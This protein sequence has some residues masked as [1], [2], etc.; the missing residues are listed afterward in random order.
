M[1]IGITG[2]TGCGKSYIAAIFQRL[3]IE[4]G[5]RSVIF[6]ADQAARELRDKSPEV[7]LRIKELLGEDVYDENGVSVPS[8]INERIFGAQ[9]DAVRQEYEKIFTQA[10]PDRVEQRIRNMTE[11]F[12][13]LDFFLIFEY[14]KPCLSMID[15]MILVVCSH[16][17]QVRRLTVNRSIPLYLAMARISNQSRRM[18]LDSVFHRVDYIISNGENLENRI[19]E[20]FRLI[21]KR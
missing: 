5:F 11:D 8:L 1:V 20:I 6:D 17:E 2:H 18:P 19:A 21:A 14:L 7:K 4:E 13:L 15:L 10:I 3:A 9:N 12:L 16:D